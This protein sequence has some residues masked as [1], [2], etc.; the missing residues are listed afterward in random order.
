MA[1]TRLRVRLTGEVQGVGYRAFA[2]H[3]ARTHGVTGYAR[4]LADGSVEVVA[5]GPRATLEQMLPKLRQGP[6]F[7]RVDV[8][9]SIW[10]QATGDFAGFSV[11]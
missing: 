1:A 4:N 2:R 7:A 6:P 3:Y 11:R 9:T 8:M 5:E 10:E